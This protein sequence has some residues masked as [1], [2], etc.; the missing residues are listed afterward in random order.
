MKLVRFLPR[1]LNSGTLPTL[2]E[3]SDPRLCSVIA[4]PSQGRKPRC[5]VSIGGIIRPSFAFNNC[6]SLSQD[7]MQNA[8]YRTQNTEYE[9][10]R[11]FVSIQ[12]LVN[13]MH[14]TEYGRKL[15]STLE[16]LW[17]HFWRLQPKDSLT[18][19]QGNH[20]ENSAGWTPALFCFRQMKTPYSLTAFVWMKI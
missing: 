5:S 8:E 11:K 12:I 15:F 6:S 20:R 13:R 10:R 2:K 17:R 18:A 14:N 7:R 4:S 9:Y 1:I 3:L 16:C 19:K